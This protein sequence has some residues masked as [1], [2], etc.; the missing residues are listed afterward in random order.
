MSH[1][2]PERFHTP[3]AEGAV[4]K[5]ERDILPA[6]RRG[7]EWGFQDQ[8]LPVRICSLPALAGSFDK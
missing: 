8:A 6:L 4:T 1:L 3:N 2:Q 5:R 7:F